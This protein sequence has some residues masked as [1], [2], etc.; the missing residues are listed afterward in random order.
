MHGSRARL[1][2]G[3]LFLIAALSG[4]AL[5]APQTVALK[6]QRPAD[7]PV[8]VELTE[9]PFYRGAMAVLLGLFILES[10][11]RNLR[12]EPAPADLLE[13][14]GPPPNGM[15]WDLS[16]REGALNVLRS[17]PVS[18]ILVSDRADETEFAE[19][20]R[21]V[22]SGNDETVLRGPGNV[23][24]LHEVSERLYDFARG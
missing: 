18:A 6:E 16:L 1:S 21:V 7:L 23:R 14:W 5:I 13:E 8:R 22:V 24:R 15:R 11:V 2:A 10:S 3:F 20:F 12:S 4:C 19:P 17:A 9:V